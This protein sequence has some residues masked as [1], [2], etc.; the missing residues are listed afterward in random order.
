LTYDD[1]RG[2]M[3]SIDA[4]VIT[5]TELAREFD[6]SQQSAYYR[7]NRMHENGEVDRMDVG[8]N[9]VVWWLDR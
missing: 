4:P 7:L 8:A 6:I 9:G 5:T 1:V 3:R 2:L